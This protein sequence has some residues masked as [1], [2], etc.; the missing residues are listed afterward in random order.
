MNGRL[1]I[2]SWMLDNWARMSL[3]L[4]VLLLCSLPVFLTAKN[5]PLILL[6]TM[7]PVYMIH[8]YEE[9]AHGKFVAFVNSVVGKGYEVPDKGFRFL[10]KHPRCLAC[11]PGVVLLSEVRRYW[12]RFGTHIPK[13][14]Q[15]GYPR[16]SQRH[17]QKVQPRLIYLSCVVF[18]LGGLPT[19]LFQRHHPG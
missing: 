14:S 8:Q 11:V 9:H 13:H 4:A 18:S 2:R 5:I 6:Y 3:P 17:T 7:L 16:D 19:S 10:D 12:F 1:Q 15:R